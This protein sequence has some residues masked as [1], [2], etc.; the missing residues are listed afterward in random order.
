MPAVFKS[1]LMLFLKKN[2][3]QFY[4]KAQ[5]MREAIEGWLSY[6]P[7]TF[8]HYTRH[9]IRHSD[10]IILQISKLLFKDG[11]FIRPILAI[12]PT[13]AYILIASAYLHDAGMVVSDS[14][15]ASI[16]SSEEWKTWTRGDVGGA[17]RW[18]EIQEY[19]NGADAA[20]G[21]RDFISDIQTRF[22]IAEFVRRKH[23]LRSASFITQHQSTLGRFAFDD[24][25]MLQTIADVCV[26]HGLQ[27]YE[28][29]DNERFPERRDIGSDQINVRF[30]AILLRIGDLLDMSY[31]RACPLLLNAASPLPPDSLA[32]WTQ[33]KRI[34]HRLTAPDRIEIIAECETQ[35][36]HRYIQDWCEWLVVELDEARV[37]M[38]RS[39][40]HGNWKGSI[41]RF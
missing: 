22:L 14:H 1:N 34:K 31:D 33:Y 10:E 15:K 18:K 40:R 5:E 7:Q 39:A 38:T 28:L 2:N 3:A 23:H 26:A 20:D 35:D 21:L 8:P 4:G 24:P 32:H 37:R 6:I 13:E 17:K 12:S 19:R 9:T 11:K 25:I 30:L 41:P 27:Q 29:D 36:E 16:L